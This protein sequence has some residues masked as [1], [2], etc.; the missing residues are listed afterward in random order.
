MFASERFANASMATRCGV[1]L[2]L[3]SATVV[4]GD[5]Q[6]VG[7][8]FLL[9]FPLTY[10]YDRSRQGPSDVLAFPRPFCC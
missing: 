5:V 7:D 2:S 6:H 3:S 8:C 10:H 1:S 9:L 4:A